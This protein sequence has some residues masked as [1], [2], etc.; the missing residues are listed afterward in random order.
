[1]PAER[2]VRRLN[3]RA[4]DDALARRARV[5]LE[6]A[7]RTASL[8]GEGGAI[9][10][11]RRLALPPIRGNATPQTVSLALEARCRALTILNVREDTTEGEIAAAAAVR[12]RDALHA[13]EALIVRLLRGDALR[14]WCWPMAVSGFRADMALAEAFRV[15]ARALAARPEAAAALPAWLNEVVARGGGGRLVAAL[16]PADAELLEH[17]SAPRLARREA[18]EAL[19][20]A[21]RIEGEDG[22]GPDGSGPSRSAPSQDGVDVWHVLLR[23]IASR[24]AADDPRWRWV[25]GTGVGLY[26][27]LAAMAG[28]GERIAGAPVQPKQSGMP[29][30]VKPAAP[31]LDVVAGEANGTGDAALVRPTAAVQR[32]TRSDVRDEGRPLVQGDGGEMPRAVP[33]TCSAPPEGGGTMNGGS[34]DAVARGALE[35]DAPPAARAS[36]GFSAT[37]VERAATRAAGLLFLLRVLEQRGFPAWLD[38]D[39]ERTATW[40]ARLFAC[41]L[42]RLAVPGEDPA[43]LLAYD[44]GLDI[45]CT[46]RSRQACT[47]SK[48]VGHAGDHE[49]S[50]AAVTFWLRE[51]RRWLRRVAGIG[52][53]DLVIKPGMLSLTRTHVDVWLEPDQADIRIRRAGLD[54]DPG[55]VPWLGRVVRFHYDVEPA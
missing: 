32:D 18:L 23:S 46:A 41:L 4:T 17:V 31:F 30:S 49:G 6:D 37:E 13:H 50:A 27:E 14:A 24:H 38:S 25:A 43:W 26:P 1:M 45:A 40:P 34:A 42:T 28:E 9:V 3:V 29:A 35:R 48:A 19:W 44:A 36:H 33:S 5:L 2:T 16:S 22:S 47:A 21:M 54:V 15:S 39:P 51:C 53:A 12:F 20:R 8:P 55:W 10:L 7:L 52:I 11:V